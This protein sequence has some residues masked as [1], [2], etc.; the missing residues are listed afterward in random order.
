MIMPSYN[1]QVGPRLV[2]EQNGLQK[3][4]LYAAMAMQGMIAAE[5]KLTPSNLAIEAVKYAK[6]LEIELAK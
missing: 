3:I 5:S 4:E 1:V 6:A 2:P